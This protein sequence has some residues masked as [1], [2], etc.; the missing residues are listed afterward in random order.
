[1]LMPIIRWS[2][3]VQMSLELSK[4]LGGRSVL[5]SFIHPFIVFLDSELVPSISNF[6][7]LI[8]ALILFQSSLFHPLSFL[9]QL[10]ALIR[11]LSP[12]KLNFRFNRFHAYLLFFYYYEWFDHDLGLNRNSCNCSS[13]IGRSYTPFV[14]TL[15]GKHSNFAQS[16]L[17]FSSNSQS[18]ESIQWGNEMSYN[19]QVQCKF[20]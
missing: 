6:K 3:I 14:G 2:T 19:L 7:F 20:T 9:H 17:K 15:T 16:V 5:S 8:H 12:L 1:M 13:K 18:W 11:C 10:R 4:T